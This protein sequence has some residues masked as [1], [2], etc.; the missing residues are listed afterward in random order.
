MHL[1]CRLEDE[2]KD[3]KCIRCA[4]HLELKMES[5]AR[6]TCSRRNSHPSEVAA[7]QKQDVADHLPCPRQ[8]WHDGTPRAMSGR[9]HRPGGRN[10]FEAAAG[11]GAGD[12]EPVTVVGR[13]R[14]HI[15]WWRAG[16]SAGPRRTIGFGSEMGLRAQKLTP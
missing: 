2:Q 11:A 9:G 12:S 14:R 1:V 10:P 3:L 8:H 7:L 15:V 13:H 16:I 5:C 4:S 6:R